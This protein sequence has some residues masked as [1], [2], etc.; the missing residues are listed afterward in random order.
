MANPA[1]PSAVG[2]LGED[3]ERIVSAEPM[4]PA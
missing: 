1:A 2:F 4:A 3:I